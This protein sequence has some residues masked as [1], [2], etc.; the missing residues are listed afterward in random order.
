MID[1]TQLEGV[2]I[3]NEEGFRSERL[4]HERA[5]KKMFASDGSFKGK[6]RVFACIFVL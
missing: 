1:Q 6:K 4:L 3:A 5:V 2:V